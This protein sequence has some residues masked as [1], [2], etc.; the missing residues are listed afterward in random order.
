MDPHITALPPSLSSS[1]LCKVLPG[2]K[3]P[4]T[5]SLV[6]KDPHGSLWPLLNM[7]V[8]LAVKVSAQAKG[9]DCFPTANSFWT[10]PEKYLYAWS[11]I[12]IVTWVVPWFHTNHLFLAAKRLIHVFNNE[13][14]KATDLLLYHHHNLRVD[15]KIFPRK[16][17]K[18]F[19]QQQYSKLC[20]PWQ[21]TESKGPT[22]SSSMAATSCHAQRDFSICLLPFPRVSCSTSFPQPHWPPA[23]PAFLVLPQDLCTCKQNPSETCLSGGGVTETQNF[24]SRT[25]MEPNMGLNDP[26]IKTWTETKSRLLNQLSHPF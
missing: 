11:L 7:I 13:F 26:E 9:S 10:L 23:T 12:H 15:C 22:P 16:S 17:L 5:V 25:I 20:C 19:C 21:W 18:F 4:T 6:W 24:F 8:F 2:H 14:K 3:T 1:P